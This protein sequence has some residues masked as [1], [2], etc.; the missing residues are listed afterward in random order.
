M[1]KS[2][3]SSEGRG[4]LAAAL[5]QLQALLSPDAAKA[6]VRA[7]DILKS[8]PGQPDVLLLLAAALQRQAKHDE[9]IAVL[10]RIVRRQ[11]QH[12]AAWRMLGDACAQS[13][14][15]AEA[16]KAYLQHVQASVHN[17]VLQE[18][19]KAMSA[20][21]L[22]EAER[23]LRTTLK[24]N[25]TDVAALRMLAEVV[26]RD[27]RLEEAESLL[28]RV[29]E[30][31]PGFAAA[32]AH[33]AAVLNRQ[34]KADQALAQVAI[35]RQAEPQHPGYRVLEAAVLARLGEMER[36][37]AAYR[38][39]LAEQPK[40]PKVWLSLGHTLKTAGRQ[41]EAVEA[42][43][44][45]LKLAPGL[46]EAW[47]SLANLKTFRFA[48][49]EIAA[50]RMQLE[51]AELPEGERVQL[52]FALGK[53]L[54]DRGDY[55]QS[56]EQY[57]KANGLRRA[58]SDYEAVAITRNKETL[59]H[60]L[61]EEFFRSRAQG[62]CEAPDPIFIVGLP[63]SGSTLVEQILASHSQVEG[64][65]ELPDIFA[66]VGREAAGKP[67]Y[68]DAIAA[69]T[70]ERRKALGEEYL[71]R[72]KVHRRLGRAFFIDKLPNNFLQTGF[73]ALILP[74]AKIIDVRRE[75][76]ACGFSC[77]KQYFA[78]GQEFSY[79]LSDIGR[80]YADY[81]ALMAHFDAVLPGRVHHVQYEELV[82]DLEG[83]VRRLL[84]YCGLG[85]EEA[86]LRFFENTRIVQTASS[87]QVRLPV[88][89]DALEHWRHFESWLA[90][91]K[92]ALGPALQGLS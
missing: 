88:Y 42:Y 56:F 32:R 77:F 34:L 33:Y 67:F 2:S 85:F 71:A 62:G 51:H 5:S 70:P 29:L 76:M 47:W 91:L 43:R 39:L 64:T 8:F 80:Y 50:I 21:R 53:A 57:A 69:F 78:R 45:S 44:E 4:G 3:A 86:C 60:V 87:E 24:A 28:K 46:G 73:I 48:A 25:P 26:A 35:L 14:Q 55:A 41:A 74:K 1:M 38:A 66:M 36:A 31:C 37:I 54:E 6:E 15:A 82:H 79:S 7:R 11:P 58:H 90:P 13:G 19:S 30:L 22:F 27:G 23:T 89:A 61:T 49:E 75:P 20:N 81:V 65:M 59:Q 84:D 52:H 10:R 18:V 17:R 63:R 68:P 9:A 40:L 16:D 83:S 92:D 12:N 72:T